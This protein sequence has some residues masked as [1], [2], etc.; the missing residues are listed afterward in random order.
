TGGFDADA[1]VLNIGTNDS[2]YVGELSSDPTEQQAYVDNFDR[3]YG[4]MLDAIHKANPR[5]V[6]LCVLGQMGGHSLLFESIQ[7][8]VESYRTRYPDSKIAYYRMKFGEDATE[9]TTYHPGVAS[10]KRDAEDVVEQL[11]ELMK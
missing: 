4:E 5:A 2:S 8:N 7:R 10:H 6:I 11:R 9:A 1:V 3:L